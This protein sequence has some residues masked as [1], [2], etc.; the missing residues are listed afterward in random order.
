[1]YVPLPFNL[2]TTHT[3]NYS[4]LTLFEISRFRVISLLQAGEAQATSTAPIRAMT[5]EQWQ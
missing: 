2:Y 3:V 1:M 4:N 5:Q